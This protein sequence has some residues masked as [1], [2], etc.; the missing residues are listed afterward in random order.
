M[1]KRRGLHGPPLN[2]HI[3]NI[4]GWIVLDLIIVFV[5]YTVSYSARAA[6]T[7]LNYSQGLGFIFFNAGVMLVL[8]NVFVIGIS[9]F[10][11]AFG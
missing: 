9:F 1:N 6:T 7:P 4:M 10:L 2:T 11:S 5:A 3:K 8:F